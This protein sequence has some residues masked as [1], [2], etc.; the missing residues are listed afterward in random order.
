MMSIATLST[1]PLYKFRLGF[2]CVDSPGVRLESQS[3]LT[4]CMSCTLCDGN[5]DLIDGCHDVFQ[6]IIRRQHIENHV[7]VAT[8]RA[9]VS[10][11]CDFAYE[12]FFFHVGI[13]AMMM[14]Q[15]ATHRRIATTI[16]F[17]GK[18]T[19]IHCQN[20]RIG[21]CPFTA[22]CRTPDRAGMR[23]KS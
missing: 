11:L 17:H 8:R 9:S 12:S 6:A 14:R 1:H 7:Y 4:N 18:V 20:S 23:H 10:T 19:Q 16:P 3:V 21:L 2:V 15:N 13:T 22:L 5:H